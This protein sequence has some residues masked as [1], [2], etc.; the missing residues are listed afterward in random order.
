MTHTHRLSR[1]ATLT[2]AGVLAIAATLVALAIAGTRQ[3][4]AAARD[5]HHTRGSVHTAKQVAFHDAMR[6]LWE[7]H[8]TWTRLAIVSFAGN[9]PDLATTE[10][11]LLR[12]QADIGDAVQ[13]FY[14]RAAGDK[15]TALLKEHITGAV[16]VL[17]AAKSGDPTAL[18]QAKAAWYRNARRIADFL[19]AANPRNWPRAAMRAMMRKHLDQTFEEAADYLAGRYQASVRDYDAVH[20]HILEMADMLGSGIVKQFLGRFR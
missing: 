12:N 6:K 8:I 1:R 15:L 5:D 14:G 4:E 11:R 9:L 10:H 19:H 2:L 16:G 7:D 13:P 17:E 20:H 3:G 18:G